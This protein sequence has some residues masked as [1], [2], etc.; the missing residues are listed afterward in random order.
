ML[1]KMKKHPVLGPEVSPL[2]GIPSA[3][4][5][6]TMICLPESRLQFW[7]AIVNSLKVKESIRDQHGYRCPK[8]DLKSDQDWLASTAAA[9]LNL[10]VS[11]PVSIKQVVGND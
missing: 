5:P 6:Q 2:S 9:M 3:G 7:M 10:M 11:K 1:E 4:G 8:S